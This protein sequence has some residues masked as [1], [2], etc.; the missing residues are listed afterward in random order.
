MKIAI[1]GRTEILYETAVLLSNQGHEISLIVTSKEAPEYTRSSDDFNKL[2]NKWGIPFIH[3]PK[4]MDAIDTIERCGEIDIGVSINYSGVIPNAV[5]DLFPL[6]ILNA[7]GGDLPRYRGNACQAWALLNGEQKIGLCIHRMVGGELDSGDIVAR[8]YLP[9]DNNTKIGTCYKWMAKKIPDLFLESIKSLQKKSN[10]TLVVQSKNPK[11]ALRCYP[12]LPIDGKI[13][14][15]KPAIDILRL[16]NATSEPFCGAYCEFKGKKIIIW[17]ADLYLDNENY[18]A[19]P[20]QIL[21]IDKEKK[22]ITVSTGLG[23]IK[24]NELGFEGMRSAPSKIIKSIR[25]R[26]F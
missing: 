12:R 21:S 4:I 18:L 7:H 14:W 25:D 6:G 19:M 3:T 24:V 10:Y 20:G 22:Y 11:E 23:K 26:F 5:I 13:N 2:A 9:I 1:I 15:N 8:E 17:D 16:I